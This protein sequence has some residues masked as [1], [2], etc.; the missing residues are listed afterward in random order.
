MDSAT[1]DAFRLVL[2]DLEGKS[3]KYMYLTSEGNVAERSAELQKIAWI[4]Y[5]DS[6]R[7][8]R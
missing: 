6:A 8:E 5:R 3:V 2:D 7:R 1:G 4:D